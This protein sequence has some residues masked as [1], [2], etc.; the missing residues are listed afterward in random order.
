MVLLLVQRVAAHVAGMDTPPVCSKDSARL[1]CFKVSVLP[2]DR[3]Y[4]SP[5]VVAT[6]VQS[7]GL[8]FAHLK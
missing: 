8:E 5:D 4:N 7:A 3:P 6:G 1:C 2:A